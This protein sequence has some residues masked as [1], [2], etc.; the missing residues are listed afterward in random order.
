MASNYIP[1]K[2]FRMRALT[3]VLSMHHIA[4]TI[5]TC[6]MICL[7]KAVN[8]TRR[9]M[10]PNIRIRENGRKKEYLPSYATAED[11]MVG[12]LTRLQICFVATEDLD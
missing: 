5:T 2:L 6:E 10:I 9:Y 3:E 4:W 11:E 7:R 12:H 8:K 1:P